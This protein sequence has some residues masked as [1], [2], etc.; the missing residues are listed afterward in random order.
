MRCDFAEKKEERE[1]IYKL[2]YKNRNTMPSKEE[3]DFV[4]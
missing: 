2:F 3:L 4:S 1:N